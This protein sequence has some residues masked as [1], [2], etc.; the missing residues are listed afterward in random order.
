[1]LL[2]MRVSKKIEVTTNI[3]K[4]L[5]NKT[6]FNNEQQKF[7]VVVHLIVSDICKNLQSR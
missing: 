1:M 4:C 5:R 2:L 3:E 6:Q 7:H